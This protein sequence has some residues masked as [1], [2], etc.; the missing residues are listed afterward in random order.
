M[1]KGE[2]ESEDDDEEEVELPSLTPEAVAFVCWAMRYEP[3]GRPSAEALAS[4]TWLTR[5]PHAAPAR[6]E[7]AHEE[8]METLKG[9]LSHL[10]VHSD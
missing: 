9:A 10:C 8:S 2:C 3:T 7:A 4:H 6:A 1:C 5:G